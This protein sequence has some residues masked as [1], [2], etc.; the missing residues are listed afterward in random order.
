MLH[1]AV[2]ECLLAAPASRTFMMKQSTLID[3]DAAAARE[4]GARREGLDEKGRV[5]KTKVRVDHTVATLDSYIHRLP[6]RAPAAT[7]P[8]A[9][10]GAQPIAYAVPTCTTARQRTG[11]RAVSGRDARLAIDRSGECRKG[12][13]TARRRRRTA[14]RRARCRLRHSLAADRALR[15]GCMALSAQPTLWKHDRMQ[16]WQRRT[17][18]GSV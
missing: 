4:A 3:A 6:V 11:Q 1:T 18:H 13:I 16:T 9:W 12:M 10:R 15:T 2:R 8:R 14:L 7:A 5:D 17:Q